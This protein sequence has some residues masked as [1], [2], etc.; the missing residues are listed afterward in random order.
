MSDA[1]GYYQILQV[2]SDADVAEIKSSYRDLAKFWHPDRNTSANALETFQ[3]LSEAWEVLENEDTRLQ[4]DLLSLVYKESNYPDIENIRP[5]CDGTPDVRAL[6]L[7]SVRG[8]VWKYKA[9]SELKICARQPAVAAQLKTAA[10]NW[11]LGWWSPQAFFKNIRALLANWKNPLSAQE[12]LRVLVHNAVAYQLLGRPQPAVESAVRAL[13]YA[14]DAGRSILQKFIQ[15]QNLRIHRPKPWSLVLLKS[16][17]L[18]VPALIV[19]AA[20]VPAGTAYVS[21]GELWSWFNKKQQIDYYQEVRFGGQSS[22]VDDVVVG[23]IMNIP[24]DR[25][26]ISNLYH[27]KAQTKIM[28]APGDDFDV[29]KELAAGT[30]VRLTG[31]SPDNAWLRVMIDNGEMGFVHAEA[32]EK[33][34]GTEI[35][36][37]SEIFKK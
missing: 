28:Y 32:L 27:L 6:N 16:V 23:R 2:S 30:T 35:P 20:V 22:S 33:G 18:I 37:G 5:F 7:H 8:Q 34:I 3:K 15:N 24:V 26:D 10:L 25:S 13:D 14:D 17:Q 4:Y 9:V 31:K 12:S 29:L 36:Y 1:L 11:L 21:E 19:L